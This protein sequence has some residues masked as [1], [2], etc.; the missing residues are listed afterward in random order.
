MGLDLLLGGAMVGQPGGK[1][2]IDA[3]DLEKGVNG[4]TKSAIFSE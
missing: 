1:V 3:G 2:E 4:L